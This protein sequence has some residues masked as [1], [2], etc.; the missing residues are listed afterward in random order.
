M[1]DAAVLYD[2][3]IIIYWFFLFFFFTHL[4]RFIFYVL[5]FVFALVSQPCRNIKIQSHCAMYSGQVPRRA[6]IPN[7][8]ILYCRSGIRIKS[9]LETILIKTK[10]VF[11]T[12]FLLMIHWSNCNYTLVKKIITFVSNRLRS[13]SNF[14]I[15]DKKKKNRRNIMKLK[16]LSCN[17][18]YRTILYTYL[19]FWLVYSS[20]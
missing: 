10:S 14:I 17:Y 15:S 8:D 19:N 13:N 7:P 20:F 16:F 18:V 1:I 6:Y 4:F 11:W 5:C 9:D 3:A 2:E 12:T